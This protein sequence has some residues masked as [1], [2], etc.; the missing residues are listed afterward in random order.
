MKC[1]ISRGT[2]LGPI[3]DNFGRACDQIDRA[4][5]MLAGLRDRV[6]HGLRC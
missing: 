2:N 4:D 1:C 5:V 6:K 3:G